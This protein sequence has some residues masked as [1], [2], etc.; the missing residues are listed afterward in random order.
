M[1]GGYQTSGVRPIISMMVYVFVG[2]FAP[3]I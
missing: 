2:M 1:V 3:R